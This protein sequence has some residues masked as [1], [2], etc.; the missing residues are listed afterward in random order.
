MHKQKEEGIPQKLYSKV[1]V[2]SYLPIG[3]SSPARYKLVMPFRTVILHMLNDLKK[4]KILKV[5][6]L[7]VRAKENISS[8]RIWLL[9]DLSQNFFCFRLYRDKNFNYRNRIGHN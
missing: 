7:S 1:I 4:L 5:V 3:F 6:R 8:R 2:P 9:G